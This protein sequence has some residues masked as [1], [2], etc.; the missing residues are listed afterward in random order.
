MRRVAS[1]N[2]S[3]SGC[4]EHYLGRPRWLINHGACNLKTAING[5]MSKRP[6]FFL[7]S[8][9]YDF[10]DLRSAIKFSLE[11]RGCRVLASEF[12]DFAVDPTTHSYE[13]CLKNIEEAD[14]FV[15]LIGGRVGGWYDKE[16]RISI[17]QQEYREA[18]RRHQGHGLRIVSFV[19]T[20]VWQVK[21]D[22]RELAK[23]LA[24][25][26]LPDEQ[27]KAI[28]DY[29]SKFAEDADFVSKFLT[30]VGRNYET[31]SAVSRGTPKPTGNWIYPFSTFKDIDDVLQP[32]TFAGR[33]ADE[34]A[35]RKALQYELIEVLRRLLLKSDGK[36]ID[37]RH[38]INRFWTT[39]PISPASLKGDLE[40]D[41][42]EWDRFSTIMMK[43]LGTH[44][45]P[46]V[47]TDALTSPAFLD[48]APD[49]K[50]YQTT[51]AYDLI[52]RLV[53]EIKIFN[54]SANAEILQLIYQFSPAR[55][56]RGHDI[57]YI[58]GERLA[59][60]VG[61]SLRW[62][63]IISICEALAKF[64]AGKPLQ[65]PELMP[66][67]PIQGMQARLDKENLTRLE[68]QTFLGL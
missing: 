67:S 15:L 46:V 66:F 39:T 58:P 68:T 29:P 20:E 8:T 36:A 51:A 10:R 12:N 9:I 60:L 55:V 31:A 18:Y 40:V 6:T 45:D 21:E 56:G 11:A 26:D 65:H 52:V 64:L 49:L 19:R 33:T 7:S 38:H 61:L 41:V 43:T 14:Y 48:Y 3:F 13:A 25:Q 24:G 4:A 22:R 27:R 54:S 57:H 2:A 23:F 44:I 30:E 28:V 17:T 34:A 1:I 47:I 62:Y 35:Y 32:L 53:S 63:N 5:C 59:F 16:N 50:A 42:K 37:P